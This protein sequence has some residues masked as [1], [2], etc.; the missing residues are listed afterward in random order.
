MALLA[1]FYYGGEFP[2][3]HVSH[4]ST[5]SAN[6]SKDMKII[7]PEPRFERKLSWKFSSI[8]RENERNFPSA[9]VF[10]SRWKIEKNVLLL[11]L[12]I[13]PIVIL[14]EP[15]II[16]EHTMMCMLCYI[17]AAFETIKTFFYSFPQGDT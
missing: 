12:S 2:I 5:Y 10:L 11:F 16:I 1:H 13:L 9:R 6:W 4:S 7:P 17:I 8:A 15:V 14:L 3:F